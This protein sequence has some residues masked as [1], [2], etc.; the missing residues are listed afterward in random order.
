MIHNHDLQFWL[1]L[2]FHQDPEF[3]ILVNQ[4]GNKK[5]LFKMS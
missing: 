2:Y 5:I 1:S 3:P 4:Y